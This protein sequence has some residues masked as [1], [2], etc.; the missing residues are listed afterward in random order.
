MK[1]L[2]SC[3]IWHS[4]PNCLSYTSLLTQFAI[5]HASLRNNWKRLPNNIKLQHA[6]DLLNVLLLNS[7]EI[8]NIQVTHEVKGYNL[9]MHI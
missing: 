4:T 7:R 5:I 2:V 9:F 3:C 8:G 1:S 6:H